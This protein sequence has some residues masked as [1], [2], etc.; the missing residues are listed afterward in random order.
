[1]IKIIS[2]LFKMAALRLQELLFIFSLLS[3]SS[4]IGIFDRVLDDITS[5]S[6][7]CSNTYQP[8]TFEKVEIWYR[9][10]NLV[11]IF[12]YFCFHFCFVL[13]FNM[14]LLHEYPKKGIC[15]KVKLM[16]FVHLQPTFNACHGFTIAS[17][18]EHHY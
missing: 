14:K 13:L 12:S 17:I 15:C 16:S 9:I 5:C 8:H 2:Q 1:M 4:A 7:K 3:F 6:D 11:Y 18:G 10:S